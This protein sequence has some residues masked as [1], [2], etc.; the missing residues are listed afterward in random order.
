MLRKYLGLGPSVQNGVGVGFW[1]T[2]EQHAGLLWRQG[3]LPYMQ[4]SK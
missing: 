3:F 4:I 1:G 2:T